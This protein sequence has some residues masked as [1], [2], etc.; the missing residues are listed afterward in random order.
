MASAASIFFAGIGTSALLIGAG[1]GGGVLLGKAA[2]DVP[3][4][5][6]IAASQEDLPP[7]R[8]VLPATTVA[9]PPTNPPAQETA[10]SNSPEQAKPERTV[11]PIPVKDVQKQ[12][13]ESEK[14][15]NSEKQAARQAEKEKKQA[16]KKA[17]A[18]E[19]H[20]RYAAH[21]RREAARKQQQQQEQ[22][23]QQQQDE[24][25]QEA[26]RHSER[27]GLLAFGDDPNPPQQVSFFGD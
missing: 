14:Q 20:K 27:P 4:N 18:R 9:T 25:R 11:Q 16:A 6:R 3:Q 7:A 17:A 21:M 8:V 2:V 12:N 13:S 10:A 1:F 24:Q 26:L 22:Q 23:L 15:A 19:R 5:S